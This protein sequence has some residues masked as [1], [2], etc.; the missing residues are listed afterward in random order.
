MIKKFGLLIAVA[1]ALFA[2]P[3]GAATT[4]IM[5]PGNIVSQDNDG[6]NFSFSFG[7]VS[8][9]TTYSGNITRN[10]GES[11]TDEYSFTFNPIFAA[12]NTVSAL[13]GGTGFSALSWTWVDPSNNTLVGPVDV[14]VGGNNLTVPLTF[15]GT[16]TYIL[17]LVGTSF[18]QG[19][20]YNFDMVTSQVPLP[21]ALF[22][23]GT[24]LAGG[25]GLMRYR[26]KAAAAA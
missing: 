18:G 3:A 11:F 13:I 16:G 15:A 25:M 2:V 22:L 10:V 21:P 1:G 20:I 8:A 26:K 12:S 6:G 24:V 5:N 9:N 4:G 19:G 14:L 7:L 23:F 17:R